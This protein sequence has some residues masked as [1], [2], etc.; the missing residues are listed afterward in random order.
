M[1][2]A[3]VGQQGRIVAAAIGSGVDPAGLIEISEVDYVRVRE[4]GAFQIVDSEV[5]ALPPETLAFAALRANQLAAINAERDCREAGTFP[6]RGRAIDCDPRAVQ[7]ITT[8]A[9]AAQA[10]LATGQAFSL[11]W[12]C[13]DN[14]VLA[15]DAAGVISM[16]LALAAFADELHQHARMLK[17]QVLAAEDEEALS[18]IDIDHGWPGDVV[19]G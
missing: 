10:A 9:M 4:G 15:L 2:Y 6:Y 14:S 8:A 18:A 17:Q 13:A 5:V 3:K 7:R 11:D 1:F 19:G 16:P 12:T